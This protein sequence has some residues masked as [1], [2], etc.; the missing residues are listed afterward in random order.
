MRS[1]FNTVD[2][3]ISNSYP[4]PSCDHST[5][6]NPEKQQKSMRLMYTHPP[7]SLHGYFLSGAC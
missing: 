1:R 7:Y 2:L 5:A 6:T 4:M 3:V